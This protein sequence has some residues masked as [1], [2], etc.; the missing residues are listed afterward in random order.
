MKN[1]AV[2]AVL[3]TTLLLACVSSACSSTSPAGEDQGFWSALAFP[4]VPVETYASVREMAMA[5]DLVVIAAVRDVT[6]GRE[7]GDPREPDNNLV[8]SLL[9]QMTVRDVIRGSMPDGASGVV[10]WEYTFPQYNAKQLADR[11]SPAG[12]IDDDTGLVQPFP[13]AEV[14]LFLKLRG[15]AGS[16]VRTVP[17]AS[18][19]GGVAY[20]LTTP[21]GMVVQSDDGAAGSPLLGANVDLSADGQPLDLGGPEQE[22]AEEIASHSFGEVIELARSA[23][24]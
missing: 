20:R 10:T 8:G 12:I 19:V 7:W 22:L 13:K 21:G 3:S 6:I 17:G 4:G 2:G 16:E 9:L 11:L 15:D 23:G 18:F 1:R 24:L 5:S 14:L